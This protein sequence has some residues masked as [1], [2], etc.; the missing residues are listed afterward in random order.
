MR[1]LRRALMFCVAMVGLGAMVTGAQAH[2]P[3]DD[4]GGDHNGGCFHSL[5]NLNSLNYGD[6][7]DGPPDGPGLPDLQACGSLELN[8]TALGIVGMPGSPFFNTVFERMTGGP[9]GQG[10]AAPL[11]YA[12]QPQQ[13]DNSA[14]AS[15]DR[16]I[17]GRNADFAAKAPLAAGPAI[18]PNL[19]WVRGAGRWGNYDGVNGGPGASLQ[20]GAVFAGIDLPLSEGLRVGVAGGWSDTSF[21]LDGN[22]GSLDS[23][24][25][26]ASLYATGA[27]GNWRTKGIVSYE[28]YDLSSARPV[29]FD[30][31]TARADYNA[32]HVEALGEVSYVQLVGPNAAIEPYLSAGLSWV[33]VDGFT[34]KVNGNDYLTAASQDATWPY[35]LVGLRLTGAMNIGNVLVNPMVDLGWRHVFGDTDP[36]VAFEGLDG[37]SFSVAGMPIAENS[38]V[39]QAGFDAAFT[40]TGWR[41]SVKYKGDIAQTAQEHTVTGGVAVPF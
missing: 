16:M 22:A 1:N 20:T 29:E 5:P 28:R 30:T 3:G 10:G 11:G 13:P 25:W 36:S 18:D 9:A 32:D 21:D 17:E 34:E 41:T 19:V 33:Q 40:S 23:D 38:L 27:A 15:L 4:D 31:A 12:P 14:F 39:V 7:P 8:A 2:H 35:T 24:A 37:E 6:Y 26:H